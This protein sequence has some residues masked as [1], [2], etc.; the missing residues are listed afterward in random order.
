MTVLLA[1]NHYIVAGDV[2]LYAIQTAKKKSVHY[3]K[4]IDFIMLDAN[5][6]PFRDKSF[7]TIL[8]ID[9]L[10]HLK[11]PINALQE[12]ERVGSRKILIN[13]PNYDFAYLLYPNLLPE[14]FN[15]PSHMQRTNIKMLKNWFLNIR[16]FKINIYGS[17]IPLPLPFIPFSYILETISKTFHIK[18]KRIYFQISCEILLK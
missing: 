17:Y 1:K 2:N 9:V 15:E 3:R 14:H 11:N 4:N 10:E 7:D 18:P 6:L 12:A 8:M 5:N 13:V 16:P